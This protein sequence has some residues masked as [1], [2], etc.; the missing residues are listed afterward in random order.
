M[1]DPRYPIGQYTPQP[2]SQKIK[3]EWLGQIK[4]LPNAIEAAIE[5]LDEHQ[6]QTSYRDGGWTVHQLV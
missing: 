6:V 5:N 3:E 1:N 2:F 4:F